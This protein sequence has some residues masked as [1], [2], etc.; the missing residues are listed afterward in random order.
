MRKYVVEREEELNS[1]IIG[2]F[3]E[4]GRLYQVEKMPIEKIYE[5]LDYPVITFAKILP[6]IDYH[7][8]EINVITDGF[9]DDDACFKTRFNIKF[10]KSITDEEKLMATEFE[11]YTRKT[12]Y[13]EF[14][15]NSFLK[16]QNGIFDKLIY[17][18]VFDDNGTINTIFNNK[19]E[20][21]KDSIKNLFPSKKIS[22]I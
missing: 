22:Y 4:I 9:D 3:C 19:F 6:P 2:L 14:C 8:F 11:F 21:D 17:N 18:C 15:D 20:T 7:G 5:E 12:V 10:K 16:I 13:D 1:V